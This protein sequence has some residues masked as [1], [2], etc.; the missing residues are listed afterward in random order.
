M[1]TV[2]Y[3]MLFLIWVVGLYVAI[4][5][6]SLGMILAYIFVPFIAVP[7]SIMHD[8]FFSFGEGLFELLWVIVGMVLVLRED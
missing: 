8:L 3:T 2:G 6:D 5:N 1:K 4:V 7:I